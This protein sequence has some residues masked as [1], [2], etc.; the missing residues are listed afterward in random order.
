MT[1][2]AQVSFSAGEISPSL[3]Q[4]VD[5]ARY[6]TALKRCQNFFVRPTGGVSNRPGLEYCATVPGAA[7]SCVIPFVFSEDEAYVLLFRAGFLQPYA[8]GVTVGAPI[9][10]PYTAADLDG[11]RLTQSA[12]VMTLVHVDYMPREVRRT[13]ASTFTCAAITDFE[14]GPFLDENTTATT[15]TASAATGAGITITASASTFNANHVGA[16]VRLSEED[17]SAIT[18]WEPGK[19]LVA[20]G[21]NPNGLLRRS[22][23]KVYQCT[24][25]VVAGA[26][27]TWTGT[28]RPTHDEGTQSDGDGNAIPTTA[29]AAGVAWLYL[30]SG[31][32]IAKIVGYTSPTVVTAD[33]VDRIPASCVT[34]NTTKVWQ[35]G[36][37][38]EDQGYPSCVTYY[39]D[40]LVF[41]ATRE[42]PQTEWASKVGD[43]HNFSV[44]SPVKDDD[45][46]TQ[47]LNARQINPIREL[48]PLDQ[49]LALTASAAWASPR[50]G[51]LWTPETLGFDPQSYN[52][53]ADMRAV[54]TGDTAIYANPFRTRLRDVSYQFDSD[55]FRGVELTVFARHLFHVD[56]TIVDMD[57][58]EEPDGLLW[59]VRSDGT[60]CSLTYLRE[61]EVL[62]WAQ[63]DT[64][65]L[66][67]RVC[68]IPENGRDTPYF[69]V[70]RQRN[71]QTVRYLERFT[72]RE[73]LTVRDGV[74][75]DSALT[76][77]G[78]NTG[79][80][81]LELGGGTFLA[82]SP[83]Q[84]LAVDPAPGATLSGA[85]GQVVTFSC[86]VKRSAGSRHAAV[87][88]WIYPSG[89]S[90]V[91]FA[92]S[93][94]TGATLSSGA[95]GAGNILSTSAADLGGGRWR[96]SVT[97]I[98]DSAAEY[99]TVY[100]APYN[101]SG[102]NYAGDGVS[103]LALSN[104]V[105]VMGAVADVGVNLLDQPS[106]FNAGWGLFGLLPFGAGS[107]VDGAVA[108]D[109]TTT[110][111][112]IVENT[113]NAS[114]YIEFPSILVTGGPVVF[115]LSSPP[116]EVRLRTG[117][118]HVRCRVTA[119]VSRSELT[120]E[121]ISDVPT[122]LQNV[123]TDDWELAYDTISGLAHLA[124]R[125]VAICADGAEEPRGTVS[126]AGVLTLARPAAVVH[127]GLPYV[128]ELETLDLNVSGRETIRDRTKRIASLAVTVQDTVGLQVGAD[129][130]NLEP[131]P[132]R[133]DEHYDDAIEP[134]S[135]VARF[136]ILN[137]WDGEGRILIRQS[138]PLPATVLAVMP[139]TDVGG[140]P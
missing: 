29:T 62:G 135:G 46:I 84:C 132:Q 140:A 86:D 121:P 50:R 116:D 76:L 3:A 44:S 11:L 66:V 134:L 28:V 25:N 73:L 108:A 70:A 120:V 113:A 72:S 57:Y 60:L 49:L 16:L 1:T 128:A 47:T 97:G 27:G 100:A 21:G 125:E 39:S 55:K 123:A 2:L 10:V 133:E 36:A 109:G 130:D 91:D 80:V 96:L 103:G 107:V 75:V 56:R 17:L 94:D 52:G 114:H 31:F 82:D 98:A 111:D 23:G 69:I 137:T 34:A 119:V 110:A 129:E 45:A 122:A 79:A 48:V 14:G 6:A 51:E 89:A 65:G 33:V 101:G 78:R 67:E 104:A 127:A 12:D 131:L 117:D 19:L 95:Y 30:H 20:S 40:R 35:L 59:I 136:R 115:S 90:G 81:T 53:S 5:L 63:H 64:D 41:A 18:P 37:W 68:V 102:S 83:L 71:G 118:D 106:A 42:Q 9:A 74:F 112:V 38:S 99:L 4:R 139:A 32:G 26:N 88:F 77:D 22:D 126:A 24:T 87:G 54:V 7:P 61:Q 8:D 105:L 15:M 92:A 58:A 124:E 43:Y 93:L 138:A 13:G 85:P